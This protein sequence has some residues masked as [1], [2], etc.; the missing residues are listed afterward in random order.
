M[1]NI[2][3]TLLEAK[4]LTVNYR[5]KG[6]LPF[7]GKKVEAL[8]DVSLTINKGDSFGI[9][10]ESGCGKS[11]FGNAVLGLVPTT[12]GSINFMGK[13]L[14]KMSGREFNKAR[15]NMQVIFQDPFS[16]LNPR[17][18]V[19][20]IIT[21]PMRIRGGFSND[22]M[23]HRA[24]ELL[25]W[26]GLSERDL[27]RYP[28]DF[29]G[30]QKQRIAIARAISMSPKLLIC[31]EPVSALDVSVHAQI[32]NLLMDLRKKLDITYIFISHNLAAVR[33]IC[34]YMAVMYLGNIMEYGNAH[35]IF[36]NP[37]HPYTQALI[38][39]VLN[40]DPD[41]RDTRIILKGD[42]PSPIDPPKGCRFSG[43]CPNAA[44]GCAT[45]KPALRKMGEGHFAACH[46]L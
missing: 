45:M 44:A 19:Y 15:L 20:Q 11:T 9:V 23:A 4:N 42:I 5:V 18:N 37:R 6:A 2:S 36:D 40:T 43:R 25:E 31:D 14:T 8:T 7:T 21:E 26:V 22:E 3:N 1:E 38:S 34:N 35:T 28:S 32:I 27:N 46:N 29:S 17:F 33:S 12:S 30:G 39:A 24:V 10:G 13:D 16:S 41:A